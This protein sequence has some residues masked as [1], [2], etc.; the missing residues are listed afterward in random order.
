MDVPLHVIERSLRRAV[1]RA[2]GVAGGGAGKG[3]GAGH[4]AE[5]AGAEGGVTPDAAVA[6]GAVFASVATH[7]VGLA[8]R[9]AMRRAAREE[10]H[11]DDTDGDRE[12]GGTKA[13]R[14]RIQAHDAYAAARVYAAVPAPPVD[15]DAG[16]Y[17]IPVRGNG[18]CL[19]TSLRLAWELR[20][21]LRVARQCERTGAPF[22]D[23][24]PLLDG[25]APAVLRQ[26]D[27]IRDTIVRWYHT[28]LNRPLPGG[29]ML[30]DRD[31]AGSGA[32]ARRL[33]RGDMIVNFLIS[34]FGKEGV[35]ETLP[36]QVEE[37]V[38]ARA[39]MVAG[40]ATA[41]DPAA[42]AAPDAIAA[43]AAMDARLRTARIEVAQR[44]REL[45][46]YLARMADPLA[47]G[48]VPEWQ[49][50][51]YITLVAHI[52][53]QRC[54]TPSTQIT[55]RLCVVPRTTPAVPHLR[56]PV[57]A[58]VLAVD[59]DGRDLSAS[60]GGSGTGRG[61]AG[62]GGAGTGGGATG[63]G[64]AAVA[65]AGEDEDTESDDSGERDDS[66]DDDAT[67]F[68]LA[69]DGKDADA[70]ADTDTDKETDDESESELAPLVLDAP[71]PLHEDEAPFAARLLHVSGNHYMTLVTVEEAVL[72][73]RVYGP[74]VLA[75]MMTLAAY[76]A[77]PVM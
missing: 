60:M 52:V 46:R 4:V 12:S 36:A 56:A 45:T 16:W 7:A 64:G 55:P 5:G 22:T 40:G 74:G 32:R 9:R 73:W 11:K 3:A 63:A 6:L 13:K 44:S 77:R 70:A 15:L 10:S 61:A 66:T 8:V 21:A 18:A 38:A 17:V 30:R 19:F 67:D 33:T 75:S 59:A 42:P 41:P 14:P 20:T 54:P 71:P 26:G 31:D 29:L 76:F 72:L 27:V 57:P 34:D 2:Q 47:W 39:S 25:F 28:G 49:A 62:A 53:Y 43:L 24:P 1:R 68:A 69:S 58:D 48:S 50:W 37:L 35:P 23:T 51:A 65:E